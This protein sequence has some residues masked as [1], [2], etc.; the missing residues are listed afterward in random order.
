MALIIFFKIM[1]FVHGVNLINSYGVLPVILWHVY[2]SMELVK[3]VARQYVKIFYVYRFLDVLQKPS[4]V[5]LIS[6]LKLQ[7]VMIFELADIL[8][9][10]VYV[11]RSM[12]IMQALFICCFI[13][14]RGLLMMLWI[15]PM[16][17]SFG[18]FVKRN[19]NLYGLKEGII[20]TWN[21]IHNTSSI[22][23]NS[24]QPLRNLILEKD[25]FHSLINQRSLGTAQNLGRHP[26]QARLILTKEKCQG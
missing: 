5:L 4:N 18:N 21:Y 15:G 9:C 8:E 26:D 10:M 22:S 19:M 16:V 2:P 13:A 23:K 6:D 7:K 24:F 25:L 11:S 20:V 3:N 17:S 1:I 14:S 12:L